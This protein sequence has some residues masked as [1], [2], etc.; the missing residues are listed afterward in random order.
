MNAELVKK[1]LEKVLDPHI[2]VTLIS[3]R[4]RQLNSGGGSVSRPLILDVGNLGLADIALREIIE[5]KMG[6]EVP[7][8][9][10]LTRPTGKNRKRPQNW[11]KEPAKPAQDVRAK[12]EPALSL[13]HAQAA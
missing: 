13:S 5:G 2:L 1:A 12:R 9:I 6:W 7:E 10:E 4:V 3:R 8:V 11:A